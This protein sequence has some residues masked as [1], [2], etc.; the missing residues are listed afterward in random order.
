MKLSNDL[1]FDIDNSKPISK[2]YV[3]KFIP[4]D[5][6]K[7]IDDYKIDIF[8]IKNAN[9]IESDNYIDK[10]I[11]NQSEKFLWLFKKWS[12]DHPAINNSSLKI[13]YL[14]NLDPI[15]MFLVIFCAFLVL[16]LC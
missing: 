16:I 12:Y 5:F 4:K 11:Y 3:K 6:N 13:I 10:S 7:K 8:I 1:I 14:N 2:E 9:D 15:K